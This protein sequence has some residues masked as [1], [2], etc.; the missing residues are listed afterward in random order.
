MASNTARTEK[1]DLR[2]SSA[3]KQALRRAAAMDRKSLSEFVLDSA[4]ARA[5]QLLADQIRIELSPETWA[6]FVEALDAPPCPLA[7]RLAR[8]LAEPSVFER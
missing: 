4:L 5:E 6:A 3:A 2:I 7:P 8:L 1:M